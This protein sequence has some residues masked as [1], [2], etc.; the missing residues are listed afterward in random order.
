[1]EFA[2]GG[3]APKTHPKHFSG[4]QDRE[5]KDAVGAKP[6]PGNLRVSFLRALRVCAAGRGERRASGLVP[7]VGGAY[8]ISIRDRPHKSNHHHRRPARTPA[9]F[10]VREAVFPLINVASIPHPAFESAKRHSRYSCSFPPP[11]PLP[12]SSRTLSA[13]LA[14]R[15][16][17]RFSEQVRMRSHAHEQDSGRSAFVDQMQRSLS[18]SNAFE[19]TG[20][21]IRCRGAG[22]SHRHPCRR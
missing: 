8:L 14:P 11:V 19:K 17:P 21:F 1:M 18:R 2:R 20:V 6:P 5:R 22:R 10:Y 12:C 9:T 3:Y 15:H 13:P 7:W 16:C 4:G